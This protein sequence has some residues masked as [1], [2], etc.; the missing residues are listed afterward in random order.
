MRALLLV[1]SVCALTLVGVGA[2]REARPWLV[3]QTTAALPS[4]YS[5]A[6][7]PRAFQRLRV[8]P[9]SVLSTAGRNA[10]DPAWSPDGKRVAFSSGETLCTNGDGVGQMGAQIW[11]VDSAG[12]HAHALTRTNPV[13]GG[14]LDRSPSWSPDGARIAFARV[15]ITLGTGGIYVVSAD[16]HRLTRLSRQTALALDWSSDG[17]SI[18]F[19]PGERLAFGEA[20]AGRV[21][22]LDI[23]SRRVRILRQG[24]TPNDLAWSPDGRTLAVAE[25]R[26][27]TVLDATGKIVHRISVP[28]PSRYY[29]T[30][31]SWAPDGRRIAYSY[32]GTIYTVGVD[33]R[34]AA[35]IVAG[36]APDWRPSR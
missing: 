15:D 24:V 14:P 36:D 31:V 5:C 16:G 35:R 27:V 8:W 34:G 7:V 1:L 12:G 9:G 20:A 11:V 18:A 3:Y 23:G 33:G 19:I 10:Q 25:D 28:S 6:D 26:A 13:S 21:A 4:N 30:G 17:R 32:G 2:G 22:L 29:V